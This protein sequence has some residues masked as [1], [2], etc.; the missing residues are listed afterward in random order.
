[1]TLALQPQCTSRKTIRI[2]RD[3]AEQYARWRRADT[4]PVD[5]AGAWELSMQLDQAMRMAKK[6]RQDEQR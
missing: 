6:I 1:M 3:F 5:A 2:A 4:A